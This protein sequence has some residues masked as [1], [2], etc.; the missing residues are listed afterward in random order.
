MQGIFAVPYP[1][2]PDFVGRVDVI[3]EI[4]KR[5]WQPELGKTNFVALHGLGGIG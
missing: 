3:Q 1:R 5:F 4:E 2:N